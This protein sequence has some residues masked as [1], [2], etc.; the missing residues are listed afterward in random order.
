MPLDAEMDFIMKFENLENDFLTV[1]KRL[2]IPE[3]SLPKLNKSKRKHYSN[4]YDD[5]LVKLVGNRFWEE[6]KFGNYKFE[7]N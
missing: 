4:Y 5:E 7:R 2:G 6:V 1:C 3:V